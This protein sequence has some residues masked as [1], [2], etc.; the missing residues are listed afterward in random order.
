[1]SRM[2]SLRRWLASVAMVLGLLAGDGLHELA[3]SAGLEQ[4]AP[5]SG[6]VEAHSGNCQHFPHP[7]VHSDHGCLLCQHGLDLHALVAPVCLQAAPP[8]PALHVIHRPERAADVLVPG[9]LGARAPPLM[10]V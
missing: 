2:T 4:P 9:A 1:M 7:P 10:S 5:A 6:H 3:H 8:R